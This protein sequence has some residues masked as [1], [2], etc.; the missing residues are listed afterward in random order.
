MAEVM[1]LNLPLAEFAVLAILAHHW[2]ELRG[3]AWPSVQTIAGSRMSVST[4]RRILRKLEAAGHIT[5]DGTRTGGRNNPTRYRLNLRSANG[6]PL[7]RRSI[8]DRVCNGETRSSSD[9]V[10]T[11]ETRS[12]ATI[13]P[14]NGDRKLGQALTAEPSEPI[15]NRQRAAA[16]A[17]ETRAPRRPLT[18]ESPEAKERRQ[19]LELAATF[20]WEPRTSESEWDYL[21]RL[22]QLNDRR[23]KEIS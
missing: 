4:V 6:L 13:N 15:K 17:R 14:V 5:A 12:T 11:P 8:S 7:E 23:V 20:R 2:N 9:R 3:V 19:L 10:T 18:V 1:K 21:V 22:R 16:P